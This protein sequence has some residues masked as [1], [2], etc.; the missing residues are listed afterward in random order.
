MVTSP[1]EYFGR[2]FKR[3][4]QEKHKQ[5][6]RQLDAVMISSGSFKSIFYHVHGLLHFVPYILKFDHEV[7]HGYLFTSMSSLCHQDVKD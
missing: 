1:N 6:L 2:V 7:R 5:T 3:V 4:E